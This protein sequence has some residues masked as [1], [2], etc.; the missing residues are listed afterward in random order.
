MSPDLIRKEYQR[1]PVKRP[2]LP[3]VQSLDLLSND[4]SLLTSTEWTLL[5]NVVH[6]V[7]K[8]S[9]VP[10][11]RQIICNSYSMQ[12]DLNQSFDLFAS[13]Y[14]SARSF[15]NVTADFRVLTVAE[16]R[17]LYERNLHGL[18][19][20]SGTFMLRESGMFDTV[21]NENL[22]IPLY[23]ENVVRQAKRVIERLDGDASLIKLMHIV[24]AFSTNCYTV[25]VNRSNDRDVLLHA[26]FRL[27]G[28]QNVYLDA[29]WKYMLHRYGH[30]QSVRRFAGLIKHMLDL[31]ILS[32][33]IY[34]ANPYHR[35][36]VDDLVEREKG[37][38]V[39][40]QHDTQPLWGKPL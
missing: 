28:T 3:T 34:L 13:F 35:V 9:V 29:I 6:A 24:F 23:G 15:I 39:L 1:K 21:Q 2:T 16:Q 25:N 20:Y 8:F 36:L 7:D 17:S 33:N 4:R 10:T 19:N 30:D 27:L 22:I 12:N 40:E 11:L 38:L 32:S 26:S 37:T 5:S 14:T 18:F 31:I